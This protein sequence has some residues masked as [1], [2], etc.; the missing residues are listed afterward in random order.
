MKNHLPPLSREHLRLWGMLLIIPLCFLFTVFW[1]RNGGGPFWLWYLVDPS[2]FYLYDALN[3]IN[4]NWP[5]HPYHPGTPVQAFGALLIKA[6]YPLTGGSAIADAVLANPEWYLLLISTA[7]VILTTCGILMVGC[8]SYR[9]FENRIFALVLQAAP[10]FSMVTLKNS[11]Q[12]RPE[13]FLIITMITLTIVILSAQRTN[14]LQNMR[15]RYAVVFGIIAGFGVA[16]KV[17]AAPIFL[18]PLF[19]LGSFR[20]V[21]IYGGISFLALGFFMLPA[22][23]AWD[24]FLNWMVTISQGS[25]PYGGG[26]EGFI[27]PTAYPK[28][29]REIFGRP[30]LHIPFILGLV[31]LAIA[32]WK[33][34]WNNNA[35]TVA[36][37][38]LAVLAQVLLVAKQPTAN[39]MVP[40]YMMSALSII[41]LVR[42]ISGF[43][44]GGEKF[45]IRAGRV[46]NGLLCILILVGP[47]S[48]MRLDK[49]LRSKYAEAVRIDNDQFSMCARI[50]FFSSSAPSFA[51]ALGD[52]WTASR[53]GEKLANTRPSNDFWF[54]QNTMD[55]R[56][57]KG[58][59]DIREV[60]QSY[61]C[62]YLRGSHWRNMAKYLT[63]SAPE[64]KITASCPNK[65]EN[66]HLS[67]VS[68]TGKLVNK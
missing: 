68:C 57:W 16:V 66:I 21:L 10:F 6:V 22:I 65:N 51:L 32:V 49:E 50:Y 45:R 41:M 23:G 53:F 24:V 36:G 20:A 60:I 14:A 7:T 63:K 26:S 43:D 38:S 34:Q 52:W 56:G 58:T 13:S 19:L 47:L 5:G 8:V 39:F 35:K 33:R 62:V 4:L 27:N 54:E 67:G 9:V 44:F 48:V 12:V 37:L 42:L 46:T 25:G 55:F 3:L 64:F 29:I 31:A 18:A 40:A 61:P 11:Y 2:Y 1:L 17:I 15:F 59:R 28:A 30:I